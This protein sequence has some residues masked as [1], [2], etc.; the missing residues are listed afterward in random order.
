MSNIDDEFGLT[1]TEFCVLEGMTLSGYFKMKQAGRA[2]KEKREPGV[3]HLRI[4]RAAREKWRKDYAK[5][6]R[7]KP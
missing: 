4:T 3:P 6:R 2:P 5:Y 1:R 7:G